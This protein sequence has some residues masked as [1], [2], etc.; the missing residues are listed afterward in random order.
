[1]TQG[2]VFPSSCPLT[3]CQDTAVSDPGASISPQSCPLL[4]LS[5]QYS[6]HDDCQDTAVSDP[7][8]VIPPPWLPTFLPK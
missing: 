7:G 1:M 3:F 8:D 6:L 5:K 4:I 2:L